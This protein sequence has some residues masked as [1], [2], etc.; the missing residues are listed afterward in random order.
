M[1]EKTAEE[2][3]NCVSLGQCTSFVPFLC[4]TEYFATRV[5]HAEQVSI[6]QISQKVLRSSLNKVKVEELLLTTF[7]NSNK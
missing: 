6:F 7:P 3:Y 4:E 1:K 5:L 2:T